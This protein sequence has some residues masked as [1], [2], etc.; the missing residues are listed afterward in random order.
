MPGSARGAGARWYKKHPISATTELTFR[1]D[2]TSGH[3]P[4]SE[5][6]AEKLGPAGSTGKSGRTPVFLQRDAGQG[7]PREGHSQAGEGR[8]EG[9]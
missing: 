2:T 3:V 9:C 5:V 1:E 4:T 8:C 7:V 6:R